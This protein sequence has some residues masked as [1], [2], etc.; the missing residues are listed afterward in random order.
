V[1][2]FKVT[3]RIAPALP[4]GYTAPSSAGR[5]PATPSL[6][7]RNNVK[8]RRAIDPSN[9]YALLNADNDFQANDQTNLR[10]RKWFEARA[11]VTAP[12][13][14]DVDN[15]SYFTIRAVGASTFAIA[16]PTPAITVLYDAVT[17][18]PDYYATGIT[19]DIEYAGGGAPAFAG[20]SYPD[21]TEP[22]WTST[23]GFLDTVVLTWA[24]RWLLRKASFG[25]AI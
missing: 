9:P 16:L 25:Y 24:D 17:G 18:V 19:V 6:D 22:D 11:I 8:T 3:P 5:N 2:D 13:T 10:L 20:V 12:G 7:S 14:L 1:S 21:D 15:Y 23:S 4:K